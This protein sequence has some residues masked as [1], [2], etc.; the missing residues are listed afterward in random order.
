MLAGGLAAGA[1]AEAF[2]ELSAGAGGPGCDS[3]ASE[4]LRGIGQYLVRAVRDA[5]DVEA[6]TE[7]MYAGTLAGIA[8]E[9]AGKAPQGQGYAMAEDLLRSGKALAHQ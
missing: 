8:F 3:L 9:M 2:P 6:R 4:A 7:M 5:S 1:A